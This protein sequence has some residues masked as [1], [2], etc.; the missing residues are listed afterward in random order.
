MNRLEQTLD[1]G[2][3]ELLPLAREAVL[4]WKL[5]ESAGV[6]ARPVRRVHVG[7]I[8]DLWLNPAWPLPA[9]RLRG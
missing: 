4:T 2:P 6:I 5:Q 9:I 3:A 1:L 8:I 7:Q